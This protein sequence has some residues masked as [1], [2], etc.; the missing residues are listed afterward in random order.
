MEI[1]PGEKKKATAAFPAELATFWYHL[2]GN[3]P[4]ENKKKKKPTAAFPGEFATFWY[5]F[6]GD[7]SINAKVVRGH[8]DRQ[9][10]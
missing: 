1:G 2:L 8:T 3:Q 4:W 9:T 7:R 10:T 5:H 6:R